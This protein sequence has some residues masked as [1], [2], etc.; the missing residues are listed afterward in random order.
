MVCKASKNPE[1]LADTGRGL[2][3]V[4]MRYA[5]TFLLLQRR[6]LFVDFLNRNHRLLDK[7]GEV[8]INDIGLAVLTLLVAESNPKNKEVMIK[9]IMNM[10]AVK[11]SQTK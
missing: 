7:N 5:Q 2:I 11:N 4:I 9:L 3:D 6:V 1:L 10:I 8:V